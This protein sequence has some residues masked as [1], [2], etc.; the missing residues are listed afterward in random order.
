MYNVFYGTRDLLD[1]KNIGLP[2]FRSVFENSQNTY[3]YN[4]YLYCVGSHFHGPVY[5]Q[6]KTRNILC[7]A[8]DIIITM[9]EYSRFGGKKNNRPPFENVYS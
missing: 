8:R 2:I 4:I 9:F 1:L 3:Y 7:K 5:G 6:I